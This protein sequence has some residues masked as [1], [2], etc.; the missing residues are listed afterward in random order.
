MLLSILIYS[1]YIGAY[2]QVHN[3]IIYTYILCV[4]QQTKI[5]MYAELCSPSGLVGV[6]SQFFPSL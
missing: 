4:C 3:I 2:V 6:R 5:M 1:S